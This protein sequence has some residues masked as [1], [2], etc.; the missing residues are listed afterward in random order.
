MQLTTW[1]GFSQMRN[2][3]KPS[4]AGAEASSTTYL[5]RM[6]GCTP[7]WTQD[8]PGPGRVPETQLKSDMVAVRGETWQSATQ[9]AILLE[10]V[11]DQIA[12]HCPI[13]SRN[14]I[15]KR[16]TS[17][18]EIWTMVWTHFNLVPPS[19]D[20]TNRGKQPNRTYNFSTHTVQNSSTV[21]AGDLI[22]CS[23]VCE[24]LCVWNVHCE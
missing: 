19:F 6:R 10:Y 17:L 16:A 24:C 21:V 1:P 22:K 2:H 3:Q 8:A 18:D 12:T 4:T 9:K 7:S 23:I 13:I 14:A 5:V 15:T 11:L 20:K